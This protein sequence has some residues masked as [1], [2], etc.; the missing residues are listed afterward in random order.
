[1]MYMM[2]V[3]GERDAARLRRLDDGDERQ[4]KAER[5]AQPEQETGGSGKRTHWL[6]TSHA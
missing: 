3:M 6:G 4:R 2:G 1:M 5:H